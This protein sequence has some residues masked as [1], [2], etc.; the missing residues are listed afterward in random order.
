MSSA[1]PAGVYGRRIPVGGLPI[2]A[3]VDPSAAVCAKIS[4][5]AFSMLIQA[6]PHHHGRY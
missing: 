1:V 2:P 6:V 3:A 5:R 4:V